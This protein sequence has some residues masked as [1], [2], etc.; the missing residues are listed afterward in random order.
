[1][2]NA[3][4]PVLNFVNT[5]VDKVVEDKGQADQIKANIAMQALAANNK[6]IEQAT[7]VIIAEVSGE[8]WLQ[9]NWRPITMLTFCGLVVLHWLGFTAPNL[10]ESEVTSLLDVV[11]V[12][13]GG[14]V[15][16]RSGE[17]MMK[18]YKG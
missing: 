1:M 8:S 3:V 12:G 13:L 18:S 4:K 6:E 9:R 14:Y 16:G 2:L 10:T 11:K 7:S 17:K 15:I 5:I